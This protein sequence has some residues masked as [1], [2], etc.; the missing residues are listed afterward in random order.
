MIALDIQTSYFF[1]FVSHGLLAGILASFLRAGRT[2]KGLTWWIADGLQLS[3]ASLLLLTWETLPPW[4][5]LVGSN[6][7]IFANLPT[8]ESGLR[9]F[10]RESTWPGLAA[11]WLAAMLIFVTWTL[12]WGSGWTYAQRVIGF[13]AAF[14]IQL[15]LFLA[16]VLSL[17]GAGIRLAQGLL[18][19]SILLV[20]AAVLTRMGYVL[21]HMDII[22]SAKEDWLLP[23]L[24]FTAIFS[25]FLR[26]CC[27]L[28]LMHG[29]V[30]QRLRAAHQ[31]IERR[32]NYDHQTGVM[33]R[34]FFEMQA[35]ATMSELAASK[36]SMA[37]LLLDVDHFKE[38]NDT[39]G[40]LAGDDVLGRVGH[41]LRHH[42]HGHDLVG[43]L[44][45]DE[46]AML[47]RGVTGA[48]AISVAERILDRAASILMPDGRRLSLSVGICSLAPAQEF[49]T[50][51]RH[52]DAAL[53]SAKQAG[54]GRVAAHDP[55]DLSHVSAE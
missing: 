27:A 41:A 50:A 49:A 43:R 42:A 15:G 11:R 16:Y 20:G 48:E 3:L 23:L 17:R 5:V 40:H 52:A 7:L 12:T 2:E 22:T 1:A 24:T 35:Q 10:F 26:T 38:V 33:S 54:R 47:L 18:L 28:L 36:Q 39:F 37:L 44:G 34:A 55:F 45:G 6:L 13:S 21:R 9:A 46:F 25:A 51:Y 29:R 14:L 8:I 19:F 30:E 31:D 32:A 53:Y 4:L